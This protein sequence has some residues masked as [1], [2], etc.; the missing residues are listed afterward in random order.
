[1]A[2]KGTSDRGRADDRG[3]ATSS[4]PAD[5]QRIR[6][7]AQAALNA[8]VTVEQLEGII[9]DMGETLEGLGPT[10]TKMDATIER[11]DATLVRMSGTLDQVDTTVDRMAEV[12]MRLERVVARVE[13]LVGIGEAALRPLGAIE[14]AGR[15]VAARLGL[16]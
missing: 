7:L 12:V 15:S 9:A 4:K 5:R 11:L 16:R 14:S 6:K 3:E 10:M 1:M 8:D 13:V 2:D